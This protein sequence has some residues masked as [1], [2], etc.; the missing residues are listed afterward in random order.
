MLDS[1]EIGELACSG[2]DSTEDVALRE[3]PYAVAVNKDHTL[4]CICS[5]CIHE[6]VANINLKRSL[7]ANH[8]ISHH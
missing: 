6:H 5:D 8:S 4:V 2:C 1:V 3:D 7:Y